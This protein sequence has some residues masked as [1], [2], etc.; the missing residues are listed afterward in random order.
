MLAGEDE[1]CL[2]CSEGR[3]PTPL[4]CWVQVGSK[5]KF[6]FSLCGKMFRSISY[7]CENV[8]FSLNFLQKGTCK[9][10]TN[11]V[12]NILMTWDFGRVSRKYLFIGYSAKLS[13]HTTF[14]ETICFKTIFA[15]YVTRQEQM[16]IALQPQK[17]CCF[18]KKIAFFSRK[19][20][21]N[22]R[23]IDIFVSTLGARLWEGDSSYSLRHCVY[24]TKTIFVTI[25]TSNAR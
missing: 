15:K 16:R 17:N 14:R 10:G 8:G 21:D 25:L 2:M 20:L 3:L 7:F 24:W 18:C 9:K 23:G 13:F 5:R 4:Q 11:L 12:W 1:Q 19:S 22:F 6:G